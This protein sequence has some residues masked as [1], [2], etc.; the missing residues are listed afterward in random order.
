MNKKRTTGKKIAIGAGIV[1]AST[2]AYMLLGPDGK[3]NRAK[4]KSF[5][6]DMGTKIARNKDVQSITK[7]VKQML[8]VSKKVVKKAVKKVGVKVSQAKKKVQKNPK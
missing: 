7:E 4:V 3:K 8:G 1:A 2:A 6:K 5:T